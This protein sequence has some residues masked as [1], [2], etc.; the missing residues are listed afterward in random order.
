M[1]DNVHDFGSD[2]VGKKLLFPIE[3]CILF[4][5][6][7]EN[8]IAPLAVDAAYLH[9]RIFTSL[10]YFDTILPKKHPSRA[11]ALALHHGHQAVALLRE[12]ISSEPVTTKL[13]DNTILVALSLAGNAFW[14]GDAASAVSQIRGIHEM[15]NLRGGLHTFEANKKL[16]MEILRSVVA[17]FYCYFSLRS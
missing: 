8:W 14:T 17:S 12:R 5:K 6:R 7:A 15:V 13:S 16:P 10:S 2:R 4:D 9:A 11:S 1:Q 3:T